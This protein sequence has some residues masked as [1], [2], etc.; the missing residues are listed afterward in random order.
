M[1]LLLAFLCGALLLC[2]NRLIFARLIRP[3]QQAV[4]AV[5]PAQGN[6]DGLEQTLRHLHWLQREKLSRFTVLVVDTGLTD[7]GRD[8]VAAL[9]RRDPALLFSPAEEV[10]L[11]FQKDGPL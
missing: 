5:V 7:A 6:G 3:V 10:S 4:Y 2:M 9:Q 11:I 8:T 1:E